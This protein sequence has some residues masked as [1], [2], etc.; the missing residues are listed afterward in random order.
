MRE[1][2]VNATDDFEARFGGPF[3]WGKQ[4]GLKR[5]GPRRSYVV[6][7]RRREPAGFKPGSRADRFIARG[8]Q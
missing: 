1:R 4:N 5:L 6:G 8:L 3:A 7:I 2:Q